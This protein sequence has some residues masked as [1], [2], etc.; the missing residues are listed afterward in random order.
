M[1]AVKVPAILD[2]I[3]SLSDGTLRLNF[4]LNEVSAEDAASIMGQLRLF[5]WL[6]F[7]GES[8]VEIPKERPPEFKSDRTPSARLR[9]TLFVLHKQ[10]ETDEDFESFYKRKMNEFIDSVKAQLEPNY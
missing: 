6:I 1:G 10:L 7:T 5:G 9:A 3:R 4:A 2:S 8:E